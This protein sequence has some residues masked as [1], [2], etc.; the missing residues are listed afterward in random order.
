MHHAARYW[1]LFDINDDEAICI[2]SHLSW[3]SWS[4]ICMLIL[5]WMIVRLC[6][7][8]TF[9]QDTHFGDLAPQISKAKWHD[10]PLRTA[11]DSPWVTPFHLG[12]PLHM[13]WAGL[14]GWKAQHLLAET[15]TRGRW[16]F[17]GHSPWG[18]P[19]QGVGS[20][21]QDTSHIQIFLYVE[22]RTWLVW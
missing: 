19:M 15:H 17:W 22:L 13:W 9:I 7:R 12:W 3:P 8:L 20:K 1:T 14:R 21:V 4:L 2:C 18:L 6:Y 11:I 5:N 16:F 10:V